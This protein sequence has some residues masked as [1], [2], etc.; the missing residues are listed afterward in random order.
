MGAQIKEFQAAKCLGG[1][2][3]RPAPKLKTDLF[4]GHITLLS[5]SAENTGDDRENPY[6]L[7]NNPAAG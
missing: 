7:P 6:D 4:F 2:A 5:F 1:S 3:K